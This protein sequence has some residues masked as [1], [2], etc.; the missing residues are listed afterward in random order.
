[1]NGTFLLM[2]KNLFK[3]FWT[4]CFFVEPF[5][6][7]A[8]TDA[9]T[10]I[11]NVADVTFTYQSQSYNV[12]SNVEAF[13]VSELIDLALTTDNP[14]GVNVPSPQTNSPL[15]FTLRNKGNGS[16]AFSLA[17]QN[18]LGDDFDSSNLRIYLD[19]NA[20][21]IFEMNSDTLYVAGSNDPVLTPEQALVIFLVSDIPS[22]QSLGD[23][24]NLKLAATSLT[25]TGVPGTTFP[26][27]GTGGVEA[28]I[29]SKSGQDNAQSYYTVSGATAALVKSQVVLDPQGGTRPV[30]NAV[31]TYTL[32]LTIS[33]SGPLTNLQI[34]DVVPSGTAYQNNSMTLGGVGLTD[35][36]DSD[37]GTFNG[38][39][40]AVSLGTLV[41]PA[42]KTI[43][44][45]VEIL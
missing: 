28:V 3:F 42:T 21:G 1:M 27:A 26:G 14:A 41:A 7:H 19:T 25:G 6:S 11:Q 43:T 24:A 44:F 39:G 33:G 9:N 22:N 45:R 13:R 20:T 36:A 40:I 31:I 29:G 4:C 15:A 34:T 18:L 17:A 8:A 30:Q 23:I 16:E 38:S 5:L 35:A 10:L 12:Q 2:K 37:A 32:T